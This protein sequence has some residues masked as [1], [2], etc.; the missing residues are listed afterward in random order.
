MKDC[1]SEWFVNY[2]QQSAA[3]L[4]ENNHVGGIGRWNFFVRLIDAVAGADEEQGK[5]RQFCGRACRSRGGE[6]GKS[7]QP[8]NRRVS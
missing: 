6:I 2:C 1:G 4:I 8:E 7:K 5:G 3:L